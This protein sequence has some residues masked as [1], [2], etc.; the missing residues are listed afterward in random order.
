MAFRLKP[1]KSV[2]SEIRRIVLRQLE[3]A[4]SELKSVG[5]PE[6]DEAIHDARRRVKKIRAVIRL[7]RPVLNQS[8]VA[9][10]K[11]LRDVSHLLAPVADGQGVIATL[12]QLARR[13]QDLLPP[14]VVAS[15]RAGLVD[16]GARADRQAWTEHVLQK[17]AG[18]LRAERRHV[19]EWRLR[20]DGFHAIAP[21]L[22]QS[23]RRARN[24]MMQAWARPDAAHYHAWRRYVKDHWFHVRLLE[25][26]CANRLASEQRRLEALDGMLGEYHNLLLLRHVLATESRVSRQQTTR[27]LRIVSSYQ[28]VLRQHAQSLGARIYAEKPRRFVRRVKQLWGPAPQQPSPPEPA[29]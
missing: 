2:S 28:H 5:N 3:T 12:D 27:C 18:A 9:V 20:A 10:D 21:G 13:Y 4:I 7:V 24:A 19:K 14:R 8:S 17:A 16:R 15:I 25:G 23:V 22:E 1:D 6:S 11:D 29:P 26:P